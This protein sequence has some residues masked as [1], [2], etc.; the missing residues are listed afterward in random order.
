MIFLSLGSTY[1]DVVIHLPKGKDAFTRQQ[2]Y[3]AASRCTNLTGLYF[4]G[5]FAAPAVHHG[6]DKVA[7][8]LCRLR[9]QSRISFD[10]F[11]TVVTDRIK[12]VLF[13]NIQSFTL[14]RMD[15]LRHGTYTSADI[16]CFVEPRTL[17]DDVVELPGFNLLCRLDCS[18]SRR[19]SYG[20]LVFCRQ[21]LGTAFK[22][23][24]E[25]KYKG[26]H[27]EIVAIT[28]D[29]ILIY[30]VYKSPKFP[31]SL[32]CDMLRGALLQYV[33][34]KIAI[35]GDF[36]IERSSTAGNTV[37]QL[38]Q[39]FSLVSNLIAKTSTSADTLIDY[40]YSNMPHATADIFHSGFSFHFPL[41]LKLLTQ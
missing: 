41:L 11:D 13:H 1:K 40:C 28:F 10:S 16:L 15:I 8:E 20:M 4:N 3:V 22:D 27:C 19:N 36:N 34:C 9:S 32:F 18:V 6:M 38:L 7:T 37:D 2:L 39:N 24:W 26:S 5:T 29:Q 23:K 12:T 21:N 33:D 14:H 31:Q 35:V 25:R 17:P 30:V